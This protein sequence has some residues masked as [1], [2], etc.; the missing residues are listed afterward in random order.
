MTAVRRA[1]LPVPTVSKI[2]RQRE[3]FVRQRL[4]PNPRCQAKPRKPCRWTWEAGIELK[5][6]AMAY[7]HPSRYAAAAKVAK[8]MGDDDLARALA[9]W[10]QVGAPKARRR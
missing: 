8:S 5:G 10:G 9:F 2:E 4:C 1:A 7:S 3:L 6:T